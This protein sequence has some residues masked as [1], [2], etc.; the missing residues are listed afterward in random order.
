MKDKLK[1][2]FRDYYI[3]FRKKANTAIISVGYIDAPAN[4]MLYSD[5][6][7]A[8]IEKICCNNDLL[9]NVEYKTESGYRYCSVYIYIDWSE[10]SA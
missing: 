7:L 5:F 1:A 9:Y 3:Q 10:V 8:E 4:Y 2:L 6:K